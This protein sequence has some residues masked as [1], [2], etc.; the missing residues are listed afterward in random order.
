MTAKEKQQIAMLQNKV[1]RMEHGIKT[2]IA[3]L[4]GMEDY[5][6]FEIVKR[7]KGLIGES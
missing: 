6:N 2:L 5:V 7:L 3:E 4:E 1:V